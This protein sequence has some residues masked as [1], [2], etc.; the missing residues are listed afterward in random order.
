M[1]FFGGGAKNTLVVVCMKSQS[2]RM[3]TMGGAPALQ[4]LLTMALGRGGGGGP[5]GGCCRVK[6]VGASTC[7]PVAEQPEVP[8][9]GDARV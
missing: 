9:S 6:R 2:C 7:L 5:G 1:F 4:L 3:G 8:G